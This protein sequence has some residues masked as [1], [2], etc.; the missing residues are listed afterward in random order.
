VTSR[1][2]IKQLFPALHSPNGAEDGMDEGVIGVP[3]LLGE[4]ADRVSSSS[5][6]KAVSSLDLDC[7]RCET[8]V[9][10]GVTSMTGWPGC[11]S[12]A[13]VC[14][15]VKGRSGLGNRSGEGEKRLEMVLAIVRAC[16]RNFSFGSGIE[17]EVVG[18]S[19]VTVARSMCS[20][21]VSEWDGSVPN[22]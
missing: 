1:A 5:S 4:L 17:V 19:S 18:V 7:L 10:D 9:P 6:D 15:G 22:A 8:G 20:F 11:G 3:M 16:A 2:F 13:G 21:S 14:G 12:G